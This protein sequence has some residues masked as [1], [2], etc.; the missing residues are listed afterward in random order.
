[1]ADALDLTARHVRLDSPH[2]RVHQLARVEQHDS[3]R[4]YWTRCGDVM[5]N[6]AGGKLTTR[7]VDC[8]DCRGPSLGPIGRTAELLAALP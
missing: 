8:L 3:G 4:V 2:S 7:E 5:S 1:M 6:V